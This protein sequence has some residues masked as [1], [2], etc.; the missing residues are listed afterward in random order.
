MHFRP[1]TRRC[2]CRA[3]CGSPIS[4]I[5]R[6][7]VVRVNDRGPPMSAVASSMCRQE[8]RRRSAS[9]N[10]SAAHTD[11]GITAASCS[12][13]AVK[14]GG[15]RVG[16][17]HYRRSEI[18]A[19]ANPCRICNVIAAPIAISNRSRSIRFSHP[20]CVSLYKGT[21]DVSENIIEM[22]NRAVKT[23]RIASTVLTA[24]AE[25]RD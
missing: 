9:T 20:I 4:S 11:R 7:V 6:S 10:M 8:R 3:M 12:N 16:T 23:G 18:H 24:A 1:R 17:P 13:I 14:N 25:L 15:H 21:R 22:S 2:R 19:R 5:R